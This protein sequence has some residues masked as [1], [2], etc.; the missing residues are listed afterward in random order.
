LRCSLCTLAEDLA[1]VGAW[2]WVPPELN[3]GRVVIMNQTKNSDASDYELINERQ[4]GTLEQIQLNTHVQ[5]EARRSKISLLGQYLLETKSENVST[6]ERIIRS[7][8]GLDVTSAKES[9]RIG[10]GLLQ[11]SNLNVLSM[12][13][14]SIPTVNRLSPFE[15]LLLTTD[16]CGG[17][18]PEQE[19]EQETLPR[20]R[21]QNQK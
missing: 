20:G 10:T 2:A 9:K 11:T 18:G 12:T 3:L 15:S 13:G 4:A 19:L 21:Y 6:Q 17:L 16:Q 1:G 5:S 8:I 14:E 7:M